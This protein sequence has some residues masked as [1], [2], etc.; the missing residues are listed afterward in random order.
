MNIERIAG[1]LYTQ[2]NHV[3]RMY[4]YGLFNTDSAIINSLFATI[5]ITICGLLTNNLE[6]FLETILI[7]FK[8]LSIENIMYFFKRK[9]CIIIEGK[10]TSSVS[11]F[12]GRYIPCAIYSDRFCAIINYI[13]EN[14]NN[15]QNIS[16]IKEVWNN[17]YF[18]KNDDSDNNE[19]KEKPEKYMFVVYQN[20]HFVIEKD[21]YVKIDLFVENTDDGD[22]KLQKKS[23]INVTTIYI[24]SYTLSLFEL[25]EKVNEIT[26][27][28]VNKIASKRINQRFIYI[29]TPELSKTRSNSDDDN[30]CLPWREEEFLSARSFNNIFFENKSEVIKKLDFF[31]H[32]K[33]WYNDKGVPYSLGI[34]L[35]GPPGTGKTSFIKAL[36]NYTGRH[37]IVMSFKQIKTKTDLENFYFENRYNNY[38]KSGSIGFENKIIVFEDIDCMS[39]IIKKR[40]NSNNDVTIDGNGTSNSDKTDLEKVLT[41][42]CVPDISKIAVDEPITLDDILNLWDGIR[43]T[44]GR[45]LVISSNHYDKLDPALVRPGRIDITLEMKKASRTIVKEIYRHLFGKEIDETVLSQVEEYKYSPAELINIYMTCCEKEDAFIKAIISG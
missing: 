23:K 37:I 5:I 3:F 17:S 39:D 18:N 41:K 19:K 26:T 32:N 27:K 30:Y 16:Q 29:L 28:Y 44:P 40:S 15:I 45:I 25:T 36:A 24:Y 11:Q 6:S 20:N 31:L 1:A 14:L 12:S 34:G 35:H 22:S 21:I 42:M 33:A 4:I 13:T 43:E 8:N 9:T 7:C 10:S 2:C 38:N